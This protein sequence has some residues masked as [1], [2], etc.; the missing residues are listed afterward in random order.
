VPV[1]AIC[2]DTGKRQLTREVAEN[3]AKRAR[4]NRDGE[5]VSAYH[6]RCGW[7]HTGHLGRA[8]KSKRQA[9]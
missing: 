6:C 1:E 4:R 8:K 9:S 2:P 3:A 5:R 7:W